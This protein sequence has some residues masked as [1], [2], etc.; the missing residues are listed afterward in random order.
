MK[1]SLRHIAFAVLALGSLSGGLGAQDIPSPVLKAELLEGWQTASG[2]E[3]AAL[4][5]VL[6]PGWKT[7]WRAPGEAG[8]PPR[9]DWE[10]SKNLASVAFHWPRPE[11]F[12]LNGARTFGY[13]DDLVLPIEFTP[14][15]KAAPIGVRATVDLGV[16]DEICVPMS[17]TLSGDLAPGGG[18]VAVIRKALAN[19]PEQAAAAG[20]SAAHCNAEP[21]RD[22][23]RLTSRL[24][25]PSIGTDE[26]AVFELPDQTIWISAT[27][28]RRDGAELLATADLVPASAKPFALNRSDIRITVFGGSGRVVELQGCAG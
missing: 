19:A 25:M 6:A 1:Q 24:T 3:M 20:L 23:M 28:T 27:D 14:R 22:G 7:Y 26:V 5:L 15:D 17:L 9:F 10:G 13:H 16:C 8:I 18:P 2:T 21:I 11:V 12:D 4:H